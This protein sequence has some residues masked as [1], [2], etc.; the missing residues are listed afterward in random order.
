MDY[1]QLTSV[2]KAAQEGDDLAFTRLVRSFQDLAIAIS[3]S[4]L[5]DPGLAEDA[6]QEAFVAVY[7]QISTLREPAAFIPWFRTIVFKH[8]DRMTRR[9]KHS[10]AS[11]EQAESVPSPE[12]SPHDTL[13]MR[14]EDLLIHET[15][16]AL[17]ESER[18]VVLLYYM[19]EQS[20]SEI[21]EFLDITPNTVKTRLYSA[22]Q[23]MREHLKRRVESSLRS[24]RPSQNARFVRRVI[25][26]TLPIQVYE[27]LKNGK[28][29]ACGSSIGSRTPAI[30]DA[31]LWYIEPRRETNDADW[32]TIFELVESME[33]PGLSIPFRATD[34]VI[35][36]IAMLSHL[37][38]L[39]LCDSKSVTDEGIRHISKLSRLEHLDLSGTSVTDAGLDVLRNLPSLRVFEL[40]HHAGVSDVGV[41]NLRFCSALERV[42]V[43]GTGTG[44]GTVR[45]LTGKAHLREFFAGNGVSDRGLSELRGFPMFRRWH[46]SQWELSLLSFDTH[47]TYLWLNLLGPFTND[48]LAALS[49]LD[50]L[51]ALNLFGT[52]GH[53]AFDPANST[54]TSGGLEALVK[55]P[56]L[57]WLGCCSDLCDDEAMRQVSRLGGLRFLMCQDTVATD[58]G[59][60][61]LSESSS[62]EYL[63]GRRCYGLT[64]SGFRALSRMDSL[65]G[66]AV[67]CRNVSDDAISGLANFSALRE[68][69]PIDFVDAGF[70]HI[71]NCSRLQMLYCMYCRE[72][73]DEATAHLRGLERLHTYAA[74]DTRI[75]D[76]SLKMLS[77]MQSL[78][79]VRFSKCAGISEVGVAEL[80]GLRKLRQLDLEE[81]Q[82]VGPEAV[83]SFPAEVRINYLPP[84]NGQPHG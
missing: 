67:S 65:R 71:A 3:R 2:V 41:S 77:Q 56:N 55:L 27:V 79:E 81:L 35:E 36:R 17:P 61:A 63:W 74:W 32:R 9:Q 29:H 80:A 48:G 52:T 16:A 78:R 20:H 69:M 47:P 83:L 64:D 51:C 5:G 42:N 58:E 31:R 18:T 44:D 30:P 84:R 49:E 4:L 21:A 76:S 24:A 11:V 28:S 70:R 54:V 50:G 60:K 82:N 26:A 73:T 38:Y 59:F 46:P 39:S 40:R 14:A 62:L 19:G 8:C 37:R 34:Q 15:I 25:N 12:V 6:A 1:E 68:F 23:K 57:R 43:M 45:A 22:R 10:T 13:E 7:Q 72:T 53:S 66:L 75:T 33:V